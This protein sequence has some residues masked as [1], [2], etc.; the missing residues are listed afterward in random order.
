MRSP[1]LGY[2]LQGN[3]GILRPALGVS[4]GTRHA[5]SGAQTTMNASRVVAAFAALAA[6]ITAPLAIADG[7]VDA[8]RIKSWTC[9]GCHGSD[10]YKNTYPTYSVPKLR[11]QSA[12]YITVALKAYRSGERQHPTMRAQAGSMSDNDI[13]DIA[14]YIASLEN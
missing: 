3:N 4:G 9:T 12:S 6:S 1:F 11:G 5:F 2:V 7:D 14:A 8:G 10:A 13:A